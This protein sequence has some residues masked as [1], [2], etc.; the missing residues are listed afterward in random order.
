MIRSWKPNHRELDDM[1]MTGCLVSQSP[2]TT[3]KGLAARPLAKRL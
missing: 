1:R 3:I 2:S